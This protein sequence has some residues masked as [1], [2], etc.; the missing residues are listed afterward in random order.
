MTEQM[1]SIAHYE[2]DSSSTFL[3]VN[4]N[5]K[6]ILATACRI[7]VVTKKWN[8]KTH[9]GRKYV[10]GTKS[11]HHT[12]CN[13]MLQTPLLRAALKS[14]G[15]G[16]AADVPQPQVEW[17]RVPVSTTPG[18]CQLQCSLGKV[19]S[20]PAVTSWLRGLQLPRATAASHQVGQGLAGRRGW[21]GRATSPK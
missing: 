5:Y 16:A 18:V 2:Y 17:Q 3:G 15:E 13:A 6:L 4:I 8:V 1:P 7:W 20:N 14:Q 9:V 19:H 11:E 12:K 21:G 10:S